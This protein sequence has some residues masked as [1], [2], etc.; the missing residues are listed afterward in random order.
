TTGAAKL[1]NRPVVTSATNILP[2]ACRLREGGVTETMRQYPRGIFRGAVG[3]H[4]EQRYGEMME[5]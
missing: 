2:Q 4:S 3:R 5:R 1:L